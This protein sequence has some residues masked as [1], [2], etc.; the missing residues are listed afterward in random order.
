VNDTLKSS[1]GKKP[2]LTHENSL[3]TRSKSFF[4][5]FFSYPPMDSRLSA[6]LL[7]R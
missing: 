2:Y 4:K 1:Y 5:R 3:I 6:Q 7:K